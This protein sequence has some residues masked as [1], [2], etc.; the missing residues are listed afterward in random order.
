VDRPWQFAP[1]AP[2]LE[3]EAGVAGMG[4]I[5]TVGIGA[6]TRPGGR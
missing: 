6:A 3:R 1:L 2:E 5:F 4:P